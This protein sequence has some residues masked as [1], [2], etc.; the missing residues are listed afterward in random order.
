[1]RFEVFMAVKTW[2]MV[3]RI[4]TS[5]SGRLPRFLRKILAPSLGQIKATFLSKYQ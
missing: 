2:A 1:M 4:L 3:I 5:Y